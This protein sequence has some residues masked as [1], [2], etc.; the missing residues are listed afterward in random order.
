M[1]LFCPDCQIAFAGTQNCT[2]CGK[3]LLAPQE[4]FADPVL[5]T[6]AP[7]PLG[8]VQGSFLGRVILGSICSL[9]FLIAF[10]ELGIAIVGLQSLDIWTLCVLRL[11]AVGAGSL[12]AGAGRKN[13]TQPG[14]IVGLIVGGLL[15]MNDIVLS[16]GPELWWPIGLAAAFPLVAGIGG[17][18][19]SR[20]WPAPVELP[21]VS[22]VSAVTASRASFYSRVGEANE[23]RRGHRPTVWLRVFFGALIAFSAV[24]A[25]DQI[26]LFLSK[27]SIGIFNT[28][29]STRA[30]AVGAQLAAIIFLLGGMIAGAN[31]GAGLRHG[32]YA[33]LLTIINVAI[34]YVVRGNPIDPPVAGLFA[35]LDRPFESLFDPVCGLIIASTIFLLVTAGG[36][37]GGQL[38]PPLAPEWMRVRRLPY[39]N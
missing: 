25:S 21:N 20:V 28:G 24:V 34:S 6:E 29:G 26:R 35:Y 9:G 4:T 2:K 19:G 22:V 10:R 5:A 37:L 8:P 1:Q 30:A 3:R 39:Q 15:T 18:I 38:F 17:W 14:M 36:W 16:G 12:L 11:I 23:N 27:A 7:P 33:S 13:G 31:T 32:I